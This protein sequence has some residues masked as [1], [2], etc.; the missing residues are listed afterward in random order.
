MQKSGLLPTIITLL[1]LCFFSTFSSMCLTETARLINGT[2]NNYYKKFDYNHLISTLIND[3]IFA[4]SSKF[5]VII[6]HLLYSILCIITLS[7][8]VTIFVIKKFEILSKFINTQV[9]GN[10]HKNLS[11][12]INNFEDSI[13]NNEHMII[14]TFMFT[15]FIIFFLAFSFKFVK[16]LYST[17]ILI[18]S[19][20]V[21]ILL[22]TYIFN[23]NINSA[24]EGMINLNKVVPIIG[25]DFTYVNFYYFN[26]ILALWN[27]FIFI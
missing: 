16:K 23:L 19:L 20:A 4:H 14:L 27:C 8:T 12:F 18:S 2:K 3:S 13:I 24:A 5:C 7:Q 15:M 9:E 21:I 1:F 6:N 26:I 10:N 11:N 17:I 25:N 22:L